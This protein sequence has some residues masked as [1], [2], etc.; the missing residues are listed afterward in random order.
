LAHLAAVNG[1][2]DNHDDDSAHLLGRLAEA[3]IEIGRPD[4]H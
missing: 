4:T 2:L 3:A 1:Y